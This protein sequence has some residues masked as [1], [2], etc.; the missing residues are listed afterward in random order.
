VTTSMQNFVFVFFR[1]KVCNKSVLDLCCGPGRCSIALAKRG[2]SVTG[3]DKTKYLLNKA[4]AKAS[5]AGVKIEWIQK[6]MRA[7]A[8]L[9]SLTDYVR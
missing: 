5:A 9:T 7:F 3:V 8:K 4:R 6:D 1:L 2:F